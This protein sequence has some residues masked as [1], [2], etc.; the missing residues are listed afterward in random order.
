MKKINLAA[1]HIGWKSM[2][3][4][5]ALFITGAQAKT[6]TSADGSKTFK[7][8]LTSYDAKTGSVKVTLS[9]GKRM[10]FNQK[11]LSK[12]DIEFLTESEKKPVEPVSKAP[13]NKITGMLHDAEGSDAYFE[14]EKF[15]DP[16]PPGRRGWMIKNFGPVG[17]GVAIEKNS[18]L[19]IENVE[20]G[21]P[22]EIAGKLKKGQII[23]SINGRTFKG[24]DPRVVL[25]NII[26]KAE[27][28]DGKV[29]IKI[30]GEES[31][32]VTI[33]VLG[34]Y[35]KT[36]PL[37]CEKSDK[38]V[39]DFAEVVA[40]EGKN[41]WGSI[42]FLLSTG[43]ERDL[44]VV[45]GWVKEMKE[46]SNMAWGVGYKGIGICE[47]YLR[48]GDKTALPLIKKA[49]DF[50]RDTIYNGGWS[51]RPGG[52]FNYQS[53]AHMNAAGV[54]CINFLLLAKTCG[55]D[56]DEATL[57]GSLRQFFRFSGRGS[58]PYGDYTPKPGYRDCN[59]KTGGLALAMAAASRLTPGGEE[60]IYGK[61]IQVNAMKSYYGTAAFGTGHTGGG[62]GEIWKSASMGLMVEKRPKQYRQYIESRR[63]SLELS[64]RFHGGFGIAGT[65]DGNYDQALGEQMKITWGTY[66]A[67]NYTLPRKKLHL[68][69]APLSKW[70]QSF[71]LPERPWGTKAD[72]DFN[73]PD[74]ILGGP[75]D[76]KDLL[77]EMLQ[78]HSGGPAKKA[79]DASNVSDEAILKYLHHPEIT[80]RFE[81]KNAMLKHKKDGMVL[82]ALRSKDARLRHIGI[83]SLHDLF[84]TWRKNNKDV[85]RVT[86][87][88][89][90]EVEKII[91]DPKESWYLKQ[92]ATGLLQHVDL[93]ELRSYKDVL[94]EMI[95][96]EERWIQGSAIGTSQRLLADPESYKTIFPPTVKVINSATGYPMI[97]RAGEITKALDKASSEIQ[98][99]A[100]NLL[101]PVYLN[102]PQELISENGIYVIPDGGNLKLKSFGQVIGFS[103]E[104]QE[105]LNS[106][107]KATSEWKISGKEKDKF[108]SDGQ[109]KR[110]KS[111]EATWC[112]VNHNQ[113]ESKADALP[114]IKGQLKGKK[115]PELGTNK[116]KYGFRFLDNGKVQTIGMTNRS[117]TNPLHYSGNVAFSTFKDIAH[118]FEVLSVDDR[119]FLIMEQPFDIKIIDKNYKPQYKVY[120]KIK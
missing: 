3:V 119:E 89:M 87:A 71:T 1:I 92:W 18:I 68:F 55:V 48:T 118:H 86:P 104:G 96:H 28:T 83:M 112:L 59:G 38:I 2:V 63:W 4:S 32:T 46:I 44:K 23:E 39:R 8:E 88:M 49:A 9:N 56:V 54:H 103:T 14:G 29:E 21:S 94:A 95:L 47:Y 41:Q 100:L 12:Q 30:K 78:E 109:F 6:W 65:P 113:F 73:S 33:P 117:H 5:A 108:V 27:A 37:D 35:S 26:T 98:A 31:V 53:G 120:V 91:R 75:W 79:L 67:L 93:K 13:K 72:D 60:S 76:H 19:K 111:T 57:Q 42:L 20:K 61:A 52:G 97:T 82:D 84:G 90:T 17:I 15:Y 62:I 105:F 43:D 106:R 10:T 11:V 34:S 102:L 51:G 66:Y 85:A 7:G 77:K 101:K 50:L 115:V 107:P 110:N 69:G 22:A 80:H 40:K 74:P 45:S 64:R 99:Y 24:T 58:V 81:A 16:A 116:M 70:A 25:G 36:W 114:W